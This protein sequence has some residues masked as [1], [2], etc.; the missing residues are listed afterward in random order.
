MLLLVHVVRRHDPRY[1]QLDR[2]DGI[3][4]RHEQGP[5]IRTAEC[6]I[7]CTDLPLGFAAVDGQIDGAE[8]PAF[9]RRNAD[10]AGAGPPVEN[11]LPAMSVFSPSPMPTPSVKTLNEPSVPSDLTAYRRI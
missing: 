11:T 3:A 1:L 2:V 10:D 6:D 8:Q 5:A 7:R 9:R 4:T